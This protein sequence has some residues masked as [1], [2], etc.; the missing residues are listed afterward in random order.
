MKD[1]ADQVLHILMIEDSEDDALLIMR[2]LKKGGYK[3]DVRRVETAAT[4]LQALHEKSWD[5]ILCDYHLP[6]FNAPAAIS[7]LSESGLDIPLIIVSGVI[8]EER[9]ADCMRLGARDYVMK[10]NLSRLCPAISRELS[11]ARLR[12]EH[13]QAAAFV[14]IRAALLDY[15]VTHTLE[16][17]L[18]KTLDEIEELTQSPIGFYHF[19]LADQ[20]TLCLG[21]WSTRTSRDFCKA[22]GRGMHYGIDQAGVW[23][24]CV[25]ERKPVIHNNYTAL[26]H[27][28]G[29]PDGHAA[30]VRELVVPIMRG[31]RIVAILGVGNK[32][33]D[34]TERDVEIVAYLADVA[35]AITEHKRAAEALAK[36]E[37]KYR[38]LFSEIREGFGLHE[39]ICDDQGRP[40]DY[41]FLDINPAFEK[42][43][44]LKAADIL[45]KTILQVLPQTETLWIERYGKVAATGE[46]ASFE[47][48]S[49]ELNRTYQ[50]SAFCPQKG[51]FAVLFTD[52]TERKKME[53]RLLQSQKMEAI[54]TLAGGIAHDFNNILGAIIGYADM[55]ADDLPEE[56]R[57]H[58][59]I[60]QILRAGDRARNL[61]AQILAFSRRHDAERK[62]LAVVPA[63]KEIIKLLRAALPST[64]RIQQNLQINDAVILG[65]VTQLHQ[66]LMNLCANAE[67]AMREKGG[68][69]SIGLRRIAV[70]EKGFLPDESLEDGDYLELQVADT[71]CGIEDSIHDM[72]FDPFFTTKKTGEGTG[73]GL[74]VVHGIVKSYAGSIRLTSQMNVGTSF[75]IYLPLIPEKSATLTNDQARV[76]ALGGK[77]RILLVD[78]QEDLLKMMSTSLSRLGYSVTALRSSLAALALFQVDPSA[79]DLVI[80][81]QTMPDLTG[82]EMAK[83]ILGIRPDM[84]I[85][86]CT[87]F[88]ATTSPEQAGLIGIREYVMKPVKIRE[89]TRLIRKVLEEDKSGHEL[90]E[91]G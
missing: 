3:P 34:Y 50:I 56:S 53:E 81:D 85:I 90:N 6:D 7:L 60:T 15:E 16:E 39:M 14:R 74:A 76:P 77:E 29:L 64:I 44:G 42:L 25:R 72:I 63:I 55:A 27:R 88:S 83:Q 66:I 54:G 49:G 11:Q 35:W 43:T 4:L 75:F 69:L 62:P 45:G 73:M 57:S 36:S 87:G 31:E 8:G 17:L 51:Q 9:A 5:I 48:Y 33:Q 46:P 80:T 59:C 68:T 67:H 70:S 58:E 71:G 47:S 26:P 24:D 65:D 91:N 86:L 10:D 37:Q 32:P 13:F 22:E 18:V 23:V 1:A 38:T 41:R 20:K 82:A 84:P 30:V 2:T 89:F 52:I 28:K 40:L 21:A 61:I 79:F 12:A 78:D 19:V